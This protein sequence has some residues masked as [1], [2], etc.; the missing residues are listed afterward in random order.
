MLNKWRVERRLNKI[1]TS[2]RKELQRKRKAGELHEQ[3]GYQNWAS[4][5]DADIVFFQEDVDALVT[6]H[7][8]KKAESKLIELPP[9]DRETDLS[10]EGYWDQGMTSGWALTDKGIAYVRDAVRNEQLSSSEL[11][12]RFATVIFAG[13]AA[14]ASITAAVVT[15]VNFLR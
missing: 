8:R 3:D 13:V 12:F 6:Q 15:I 1:L 11:Y 5:W 7:W 10:G 2:R 9:R 4:G 14:L